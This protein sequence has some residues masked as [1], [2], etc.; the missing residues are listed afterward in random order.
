MIRHISGLVGLL[1]SGTFL[2]ASWWASL[3][4]FGKFGSLLVFD[5]GV[6]LVVF[7]ATS[8]VLF[9]LLEDGMERP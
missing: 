1:S 4:G 8:Q 5:L 6:F 9:S 2:S 7:G 3:P